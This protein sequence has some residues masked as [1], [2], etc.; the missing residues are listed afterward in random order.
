MRRITSTTPG[1]RKM[2]V[3]LLLVRHQ[4][5]AHSHRAVLERDARTDGDRYCTGLICSK[6]RLKT[7]FGSKV[8]SLVCTK[9]LFPS[10]QW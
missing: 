9:V 4:V 8:P 5:W 2:A 3:V 6:L 7:L 1:R 10:V